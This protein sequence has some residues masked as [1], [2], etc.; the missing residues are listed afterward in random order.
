[1]RDVVLYSEQELQDLYE[2]DPWSYV[3]RMSKIF[4]CFDEGENDWNL[5]QFLNQH[6]VETVPIIYEHNLDV[7]SWEEII[8]SK[9]VF[10]FQLIHDTKGKVFEIDTL[11]RKV[12]F[13][14]DTNYN[15]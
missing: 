3:A 14:K 10:L 11:E 6:N 7:N 8:L 2:N 5:Y 12:R 4:G 15:S 1:M 13:S 9:K